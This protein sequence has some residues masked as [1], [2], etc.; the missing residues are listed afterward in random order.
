MKEAEGKPGAWKSIPEC[1][2]KE[3]R[4]I[5]PTDTERLSKM[6][7]EKLPP[8]TRSLAES[9]SILPL[10]AGALQVQFLL[11]LLPR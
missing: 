7:T 9:S 6:R 4:S 5:V 2:M 3:G 11:S 1:F 8:M 10:N